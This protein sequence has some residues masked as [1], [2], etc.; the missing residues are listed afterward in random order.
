MGSKM[1]HVDGKAGNYEEMKQK[2][3]CSLHNTVSAQ[4]CWWL[5]DV[6]WIN[7]HICLSK[8]LFFFKIH[9]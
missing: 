5:D 2:C 9:G 1:K 6:K 8:Y 4:M 3:F 7:H